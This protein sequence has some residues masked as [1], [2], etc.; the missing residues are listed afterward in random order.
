[1]T[2]REIAIAVLQ[3]FIAFLQSVLHLL[4]DEDNFATPQPSVESPAYSPAPDA[5]SIASTQDEIVHTPPTTAT[6]GR[7]PSPAST[8]TAPVSP[9]AYRGRH[10]SNATLRA[11]YERTRVC[12]QYF[13]E[14]IR[15]GGRPRLG[16][17]PVCGLTREVALAS[18]ELTLQ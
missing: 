15:T 5:P 12:G 18:R 7:T 4:Q 10:V 2:P 8:A 1:M 17:C 13:H 6:R 16:Q 3:L 9:S 11:E 14:V